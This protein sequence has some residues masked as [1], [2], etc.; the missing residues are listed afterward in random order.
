MEDLKLDLDEGI[1]LQTTDVERYQKNDN[2]IEVYE[3]YLTNKNL[4]SVY[5]K[6]N[7]M[8]KKT[9]N[10]VEKI[11]LTDIKV[12]NG[13]VQIFKKDDNDYGL[14]MQILF[15]NGTREHFVFCNNKKELQV[16]MDSIIETITGEKPTI[17][18][19]KKNVDKVGITTAG[20]MAGFKKVVDTAKE[21]VDDIKTQVVDEYSNKS[22][23]EEND[24]VEEIEE[25]L[26]E[27]DGEKN[28]KEKRDSKMSNENEKYI[29]C[30]NCGEKLSAK[31]KFCN[32]CGN[33]IT[34]SDVV[35][36]EQEIKIEENTE[37]KNVYD[38]KIH[39]CPSCGE[40]LKAFDIKCP[41]CGFEIRDRN[42]SSSL[43]EFYLKL[44][45]IESGREKKKATSI[46]AQ[47]L[48]GDNLSKT[49][50]QKI[51]LIRSFII[52][53]TKE[54]LYE[55]LILSKS[56][57]EIDLYENTQLKTARLAVSDAW[58]AKFEQAYQKAKLLFKNDERMIEIQA[59]YD[60]VN[61]SIEKAKWKTWKIIGITFGII[62]LMYVFIFGMIALTGGF[63]SDDNKSNNSDSQN[64][65]A[66]ID[67]NI[68]DEN[69]EKED[70][71]ED[72]NES[73]EQVS[74]DD[75]IVAT[76]NKYIK[77][78]E[79][80]YTMVG[81]YLTCIV[82]ITNTDS[83]KA[84]EFPSFR[85]TAYDKNGKILGSEERVLNVLYPNQS[86]VD[87]GTLIEVSEKP[88][89][90]EVTIIEPDEDDIVSVSSLEHPEYKEMKCQN[91]SVN[92]DK[93]TGE[94]YNPNNYKIE[95][96][97]ITII[98]RDSNNKIVSSES[99]F[100]DD[101]P[102]NGKIPFDISLASDAKTTDKIEAFAY[103][104]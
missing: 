1:I 74:F 38:G 85:V 81:D 32:N 5:E 103:L 92:S 89:K 57:I 91:L 23:V 73:N 24:D 64:N 37:R 59:M 45:K 55:F 102:A 67:E 71:M 10:V 42:S 35:E 21:M 94:V 48:T 52:P 83:K 4:I 30:S 82:T 27:L 54:D 56:N 90:V 3:L 33:S 2:Y 72:K 53:N 51:S 8:F 16:W 46:F 50:E 11:P 66:I 43:R 97:M 78:K 34:K 104:W 87:Q 6:S 20:L 100:V 36:E 80:G 17:T 28:I 40:G 88:H 49:D 62:I 22:D 29:Y 44:E 39:K 19:N 86:M 31:S 96:A 7:G 65:S 93:I 95:S 68:N 70:V 47:S 41:S 25:N 14:G 9:E 26:Q 13:K 18:E 84:I 79:V 69:N 60:E 75:N 12:V 76:S 98:F 99:A 63:D 58:K 101:I 15:T 77:I 61:K